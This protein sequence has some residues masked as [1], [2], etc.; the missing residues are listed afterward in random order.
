MIHSI[1]LH[2]ILRCA[3]PWVILVIN[4][5]KYNGALHLMQSHRVAESL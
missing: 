2:M 5:Y 4:S 1:S 3:A